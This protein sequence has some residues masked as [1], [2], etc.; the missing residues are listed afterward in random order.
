MVSWRKSMLISLV[1]WGSTAFVCI[2]LLPIG[3]SVTHL[4]NE[5]TEAAGAP[6]SQLQ[7]W[8][9]RHLPGAPGGVLPS[10]HHCWSRVV[11]A[12]WLPLGY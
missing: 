7:S 6:Q 5:E 2:L 12:A 8:G 9:P 4:V 3:R 11:R 10:E 1:L